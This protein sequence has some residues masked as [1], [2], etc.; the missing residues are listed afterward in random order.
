MSRF[1]LA[2]LLAGCTAAVPTPP[3]DIGVAPESA[4]LAPALAGWEHT[5]LGPAPPLAFRRGDAA[6]FGLRLQN[7]AGVQRWLVELEVSKDVD[8]QVLTVQRLELNGSPVDLVSA[9]VAM[10]VT[11]RDEAGRVVHASSAS[12][13]DAFLRAGTLAACDLAIAR[14]WRTGTRAPYDPAV[15]AMLPAFMG[16]FELFRVVQ[17]CD[18]LAPLLMQVVRKPSVWSV[19][20]NFGVSLRIEVRFEEAVAVDAAPFRTSRALRYPVRV[21][22]NGS[23]ALEAALLV[24]EPMPPSHLSAG[25][26]AIDAWHPKEP[27]RRFQVRLLGGRRA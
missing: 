4:F 15:A 3:T 1:T 18:A 9:P 5:T 10:Q 7:D 12:A 6:L 24:V 27:T 23:L 14:G 19:V 20:T 11:V 17:Q 22:A 25:I 26:V 16:P 8:T 2:G 13:G 21:L